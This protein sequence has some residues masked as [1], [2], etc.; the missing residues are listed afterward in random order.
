MEQSVRQTEK[1]G[2]HGTGLQPLQKQE[3][4]TNGRGRGVGPDGVSDCQWQNACSCAQ[5]W[6][7]NRHRRLQFFSFVTDAHVLRVCNSCQSRK[8][9]VSHHPSVSYK[10]LSS[11]KLSLRILL[12]KECDTHRFQVS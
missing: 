7:I 9:H 2:I 6:P 1:D 4:Q 8:A 5:H 11:R 10:H 12:A 3:E